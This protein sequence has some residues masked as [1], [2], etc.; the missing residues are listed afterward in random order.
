MGQV[1]HP[2]SSLRVWLRKNLSSS[3][4]FL[5]KTQKSYFV[6]LRTARGKYGF[7]TAA[8][9]APIR[10]CCDLSEVPKKA[11]PCEAETSRPLTSNGISWRESGSGNVGDPDEFDLQP[12][13]FG[14]PETDMFA[15]D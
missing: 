11:E 10:D 6:L 14:D 4:L 13:E 7:E 12:S 1:M 3:P 8:V 15:K 2:L 9:G 5:Q